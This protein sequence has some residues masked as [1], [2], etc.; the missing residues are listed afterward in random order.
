LGRI[1]REQNRLQDAIEYFSRVIELDE[2]HSLS[3]VWREIGATYVAAEM[4]PEA[5]EPLQRYVERRPYDPEGLFYYGKTLNQLGRHAEAQEMFVNCIE[6]VKTMP[7][8]RR[9]QMAKWKSLAEGQLS[10]A[11]AKA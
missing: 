1:A 7:S 11:G 4:Y 9:R 6:A 3:E 2:K 5:E 10:S 8:Y